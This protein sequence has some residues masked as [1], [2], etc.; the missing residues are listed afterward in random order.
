[1]LAKDVKI[2]LFSEEKLPIK[3]PVK[4]AVKELVKK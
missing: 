3:E 4:E 1:M 2:L